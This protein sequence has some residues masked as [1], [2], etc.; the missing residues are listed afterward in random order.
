MRIIKYISLC[1]VTSLGV[2]CVSVKYPELESMP[3]IRSDEGLVF[4]YREKKFSGSGVSYYI[5]EGEGESKIALG[6]LE[7]G[8][9]FFKYIP[10]GEHVFWAKTEARDEVTIDVQSGNTYYV[11]GD[12]SFGFMAGRPNLSNVQS[13]EGSIEI[14]GLK[15]VEIQEK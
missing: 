4:F 6:A 11:K 1:L 3:K 10:P 8:T 2:G 12:V 7:S 15:Y 14:I 5:Y 13:K 9:F